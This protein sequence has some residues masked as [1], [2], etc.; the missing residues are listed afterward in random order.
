MLS[1][2]SDGTHENEFLAENLGTKCCSDFQEI[3][4]NIKYKCNGHEF[5]DFKSPSFHGRFSKAD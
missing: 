3:T 5:G 2:H 1:Y 4:A